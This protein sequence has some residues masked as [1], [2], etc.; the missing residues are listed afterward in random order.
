M[1]FQRDPERSGPLRYIRRDD[2]NV[3]A[4]LIIVGLI[5]VFGAMYLLFSYRSDPHGP[6]VT[7][8]RTEAPPTPGKP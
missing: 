7:G 8:Q 2:S 3:P 1:T 6:T 5:M 4:M